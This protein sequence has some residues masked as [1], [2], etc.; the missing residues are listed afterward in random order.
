M[1]HAE[2]KR[3]FAKTHTTFCSFCTCNVLDQNTRPLLPKTVNQSSSTGFSTCFRKYPAYR[4]RLEAQ[5]HS[6][7]TGGVFYRKIPTGN[8]AHL[9]GAGKPGIFLC[10][11]RSSKQGRLRK[12]FYA[13]YVLKRWW[14][15]R[16]QIGESEENNLPVNWEKTSACVLHWVSQL[17]C[18]KIFFHVSCVFFLNSPVGWIYAALGASLCM[19]NF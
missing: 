12:L 4:A 11:I 7:R 19:E 9:S 18:I 1:N 15:E 10:R 16:H 13:W 3:C 5:W 17:F 6:T 14:I 8:T 2:V